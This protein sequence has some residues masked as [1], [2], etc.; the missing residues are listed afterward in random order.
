MSQKKQ[1]AVK[2]SAPQRLHANEAIEYKTDLMTKKI[3]AELDFC[4]LK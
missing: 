1:P 4:F 2:A 3:I